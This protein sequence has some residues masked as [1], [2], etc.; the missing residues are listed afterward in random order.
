MTLLN[1]PLS[2]SRFLRFWIHLSGSSILSSFLSRWRIF[3]LSYAPKHRAYLMSVQSSLLMN[4]NHLLKPSIIL[5]GEML[6]RKKSMPRKK[7]KYLGAL[8][9]WKQ[10]IGCNQ[11]IALISTWR[12]ECLSTRGIR[13][14]KFL[15]SLLQLQ[16]SLL[17]M[18]AKIN[19][20]VTASDKLKQA[21]R[22]AW[23]HKFSSFL[24]AS[25]FIIL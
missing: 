25:F 1:V 11:K 14:N 17:G 21:P 7:E 9:A 12:E 8:P 23:F 18:Q 2:H 16:A 3:V 5:A 24:T 22:A 6:C 19:I 4:L 15:F 10:A 13:K 20:Y